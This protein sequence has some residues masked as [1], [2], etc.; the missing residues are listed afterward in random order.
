M[1]K[2]LDFKPKKKK[3]LLMFVHRDILVYMIV[4]LSCVCQMF[5]AFQYSQIQQY[6]VSHFI[7]YFKYFVKKKI[8]AHCARIDLFRRNAVLRLEKL[9]MKIESKDQFKK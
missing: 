3:Y 6:V 8:L 1:I 7:P 5:Y 4:L 9:S 2:N